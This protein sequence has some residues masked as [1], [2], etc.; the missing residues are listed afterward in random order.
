VWQNPEVIVGKHHHLQV[1]PFQE[2]NP[3]SPVSIFAPNLFRNVW[4]DFAGDVTVQNIAMRRYKIRA[5]ELKNE[6][7]NTNNT[8]AQERSRNYRVA[9]TG[10]QDLSTA[11]DMTPI[12]LGLPRHYGNRVEHAKIFGVTPGDWNDT[13]NIAALETFL[14]IEPLTGK[15]MHGRQRLQ[16]NMKLE[17]IR[18]NGFYTSM[19]TGEGSVM[20]PIMWAQEGDTISAA[21]AETFRSDVYG[22]RSSSKSWT[23]VLIVLGMILM[24]L[25]L[26]ALCKGWRVYRIKDA[27]E[28][29]P[30][31]GTDRKAFF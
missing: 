18:L 10:F 27:N 22:N 8:Q 6:E 7:D 15:V 1:S 3:A 14:D 13:S 28:T 26:G 21:D 2:D 31:R 29:M 23:V 24:V 16:V 25:G 9:V 4:F 20:F 19:Y 11:F 17:S 5:S 30:L 12:H